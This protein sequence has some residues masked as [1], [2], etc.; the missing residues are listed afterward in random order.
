[1]L[2]IIL[3][4]LSTRAEL[5]VSYTDTLNGSIKHGYSLRNRLNSTQM[6][7]FLR[8]RVAS[9]LMLELW[10]FLFATVIAVRQLALADL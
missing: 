8:T 1:M 7:A 5:V 9:A 3:P 10:A 6:V 2:W 4:G